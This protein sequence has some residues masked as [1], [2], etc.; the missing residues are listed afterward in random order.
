MCPLQDRTKSRGFDLTT[1]NEIIRSINFDWLIKKK[2]NL[3]Q[4]SLFQKKVQSVRNAH[5]HVTKI[6]IH[7]CSDFKTV[8][9]TNVF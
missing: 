8:S 4:P 2:T 7:S 3:K 1:D 9:G 5:A 6:L